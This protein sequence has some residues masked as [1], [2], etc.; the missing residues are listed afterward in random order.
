MRERARTLNDALILHVTPKGALVSIS[1]RG[2]GFGDVEVNVV[3]SLNQNLRADRVGQGFDHTKDSENPGTFCWKHG[4][5]PIQNR[6]DSPFR[7]RTP[8]EACEGGK[9]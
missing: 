4:V 1:F 7:H 3:G 9:R 2:D 8:I 5:A 6:L